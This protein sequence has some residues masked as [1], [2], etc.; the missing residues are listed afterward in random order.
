MGAE[1]DGRVLNEHYIYLIVLQ[2]IESVSPTILPFH[3]NSH[4]KE[5]ALIN[6][7]PLEIALISADQ[8]FLLSTSHYF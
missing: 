3:S 4:K 5:I 2:H 1:H 8:S 7:F 6:R